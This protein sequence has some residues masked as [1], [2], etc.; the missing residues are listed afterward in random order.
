MTAATACLWRWAGFFLCPAAVV[1][2][3]LVVDVVD[4]LV[5]LGVVAV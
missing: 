2:V 3:V 5:V 4:V 1:A